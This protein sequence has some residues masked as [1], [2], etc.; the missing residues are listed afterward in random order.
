MGPDEKRLPKT[1]VPSIVQ[2]FFLS[3]ALQLQLV[4]TFV[5]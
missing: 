4:G 2:L 1:A 5:A 3:P